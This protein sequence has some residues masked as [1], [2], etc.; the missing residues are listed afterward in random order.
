MR[1]LTEAADRLERALA[2]GPVP[3]D[4]ET[5][6]MLAA[7]GALA[8]DTTRSPARIKSTR[9]AMLNAFRRANA[10]VDTR[11]DAGT[12]DGLEEV[13]LHREETTLPGGGRLILSD[14]EEITPAQIDAAVEAHAAIARDKDHQR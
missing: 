3:H 8:P 5:R 14:M 6:R 12:G 9:D 2:G 7:A 13:R 11:Q 4:A 10:P 1:R